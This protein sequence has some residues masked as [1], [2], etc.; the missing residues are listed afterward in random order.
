[1][2]TNFYFQNGD[3]SG[4]TGEQRL[5]ESL[6]IESLKI[7]GH[8][9]FYIPRTIVSRDNIFDEDAISQY[10][11]SFPLE[12]YLENVDGFEGEGELFAKFGL[13]IRDQATFVLS[14]KRWEQMVDT[15][16][17]T[18]QLE[19]RPAEGDLLY[20]AK[21]G[22]L[23]E[24]KMVEFQNPF[25]QLGKIYVYKL[26]TELFEYSSEKIDTGIAALDAIED[27]NSLNTLEYEIKTEAGN[28]LVTERNN[29]II[30][31]EFATQATNAN[32]DNA[33]FQSF[34]D[35]LDF[36]EGNPFGDL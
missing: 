12:M 33:D 35:I 34:T 26:I 36:S 15:S 31:E 9:I 13:E 25:Y 7:Y 23:F 22:S 8:D 16:D 2:A 5:V 32:T 20:F 14:K 24:I 27:Q 3:T 21:T 19:A 6:V 4:T 10:T 17:G 18:F 30:R 29:T 11:Q 28:I 1:M